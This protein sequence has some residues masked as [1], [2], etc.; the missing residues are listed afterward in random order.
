[1][2]QQSA[3]DSSVPSKK[4]Q[5]STVSQLI[6]IPSASKT[7]FKK[8]LKVTKCLPNQRLILPKLPILSKDLK[9]IKPKPETVVNSHNIYPKL[10]T[11]ELL[12]KSVSDSSVDI[13]LI[14]RE[15]S[16]LKPPILTTR[17]TVLKPFSIES[18]FGLYNLF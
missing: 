2:A 18:I 4:P 17:P 3:S 14:G 1:M 13:D 12:Q 15:A 10:M 8:P 16:L 11:P 7:I 9:T 5:L 6:T